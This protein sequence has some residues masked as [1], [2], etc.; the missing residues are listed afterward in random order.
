MC[1]RDSAGGACGLGVGAG[2]DAGA[3]GVAYGQCGG[4]G[5]LMCVDGRSMTSGRVNFG[6]EWCGKGRCGC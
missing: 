5:A 6:G 4:R 2:S 3:A 1:I